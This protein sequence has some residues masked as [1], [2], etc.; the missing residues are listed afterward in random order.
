MLKR[1]IDSPIVRSSF[2]IQEGKKRSSDVIRFLDKT[3]KYIY[4]NGEEYT[5]F[6][7]GTL[8][9]MTKTGVKLIEYSTGCKDIEFP[10]GTK[11]KIDANGR[12]ENINTIKEK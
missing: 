6:A 11:I 7:D 10:N 2:I 3:E 4:L 12:L 8:Q 5:F 9:I 1:S